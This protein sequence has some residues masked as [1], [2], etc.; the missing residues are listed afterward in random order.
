[1]SGLMRYAVALLIALCVHNNIHR[2]SCMS[3][4][5]YVAHRV[6]KFIA[7]MMNTLIIIANMSLDM[8]SNKK[9]KRLTPGGLATKSQ[10]NLDTIYTWYPPNISL[11]YP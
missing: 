5:T 11:F 4:V 1:M 3:S 7:L 9:K 2:H 10:D 8:P 6:S